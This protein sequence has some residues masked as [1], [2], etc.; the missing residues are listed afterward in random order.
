MA[1]AWAWVNHYLSAESDAIMARKGGVLPSRLSTLNDPAFNTPEFAYFKQYL[2]VAAQGSFE[3]SR[4]LAKITPA[5]E[6]GTAFQDV[7]VNKMPVALAAQE[8]A[9]R[10]DKAQA[11]A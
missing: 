6:V 2:G 8:S 9:A 11:A 3:P 7:V 4:G 5:T 1:V 10:F